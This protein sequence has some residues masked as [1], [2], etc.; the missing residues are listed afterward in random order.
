MHIPHLEFYRGL[1]LD[2]CYLLFT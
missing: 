2:H 1:F